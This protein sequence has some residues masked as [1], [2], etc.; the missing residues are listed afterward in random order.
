MCKCSCNYPETIRAESV[1]VADDLVTI[2]L[3]SSAEINGGDVLNIGLFTAIPDGTNGVPIS[4]TNGT[5][6]GNLLVKN[7][8][9]FRPRPL[10]ARTVFQVQFFSDP[11]HFVLLGV[12]GRC[13]RG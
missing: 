6:T 11:A 7:G 12:K 4:I 9:Y 3:P 5:V 13:C 10:L 8:N 1:T 2:T